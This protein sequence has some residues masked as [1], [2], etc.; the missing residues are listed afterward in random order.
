MTLT[1]ADIDV[2]DAAAIDEVFAAA[3]SRAEG[4]QTTGDTVGDLLSFVWWDGQ[5]ADAAHD[6]AHLVKVT[7]GDHADQCRRVADAAK[8]AAAAV[9]DVKYR[10]SMIRADA[11]EAQ[12]SIDSRTGAVT[13]KITVLTAEQVA[14]RDAVTHD[15]TG[16]ITQLLADA[17]TADGD[18]ATAIETADGA[19]VGNP[20]GTPPPTL[21]AAPPASASPA[22]VKRWWDG[23]TAAHQV[24]CI[25]GD[26]AA[27][28][29]DGIPIDIRDAANRIRLPRETATAKAALDRA[30]DRT[31]SHETSPE[32]P[33]ARLNDLLAID[34]ALHPKRPD[35]SLTTI[36]EH[37]RRTLV[38]LDT[39]SNPRHV[40]GAIGVGDVDHAAHVGVTT[41]GVNTNAT[42]LPGMAAEA[43]NLRRTAADIL[44]RAG[45]PDPQ[46]V[47]TVAWVGYEPPATMVDMRVASD[48]LARAAAPHLNSFFQGLAATTENPYQAITAFGHSYG[49]LVTSLAVQENSPVKNAVFYGSPGLELA[50]VG[51]L[52]LAS[53]GHA[54]YEQAPGDPIDWVQRGSHALPLVIGAP[55]SWLVTS[56][57]HHQPFG[58]TPD[59]IAGITQLST[60]AGADPMH[61]DD[62]RAGARG[63]SEYARDAP[64]ETGTDT[65]TLRMSGYNFAAVLSGVR[66]A[67][68]TGK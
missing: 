51:D 58:N 29:R 8:R 46:S 19:A 43:T 25:V 26:P 36:D 66:G 14:H 24:D 63:H 18:L 35:G 68:K 15:L 17:D 32:T 64:H 33:R 57:E 41:G 61:I 31:K 6:S 54:Y 3:T 1:L 47:A 27:L 60:S 20:A 44:T 38:R 45:D 49:S 37:D 30:L 9:A 34:N 28:D 16:R 7:L 59:Q 12:L 39:V 13:S 2:W 53:G 62:H 40:L 10:L 67:T 5:A 55:L 4:A 52:R 50:H 42:S 56:G 22:D 11:D 48:G 65:R 21:P 23:L